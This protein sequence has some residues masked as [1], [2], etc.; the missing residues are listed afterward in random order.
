MD[1]ATATLPAALPVYTVLVIGSSVRVAGAL[2]TVDLALWQV[3]ARKA[4]DAGERVILR[5][6]T[7]EIGRF[8][9]AAFV[10]AP[11]GAQRVAARRALLGGLV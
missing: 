7:S 2:S 3:E 5:K 10:A 1:A 8:R 6:V 4:Q 9:C 11:A